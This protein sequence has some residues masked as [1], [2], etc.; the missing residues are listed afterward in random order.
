MSQAGEASTATVVLT[1]EGRRR[2]ET[3]L[4]QATEALREMAEQLSDRDGVPT[5][6]YRRTAAQVEE[7]R[8]VLGRARR[9]TEVPEDPTIVELGDAVTIEYDDGET[10]RRVV[11][12][13]VEAGLGDDRVSAAS[14]L[15]RA[16]IGRRVGDEVTVDAPA[17]QYGCVIRERRRAT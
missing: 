17:G 16:L 3:R 8:G 7:L 5:D 15:G 6:E 13:P 4:L 12:D 10:E 2:L 14:P 9:P 1:D 11:V